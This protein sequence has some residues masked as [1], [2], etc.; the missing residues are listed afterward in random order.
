MCTIIFSTKSLQEIAIRNNNTIFTSIK[1][2]ST[3]H[4]QSC[5]R[6]TNTW[7][8]EVLTETTKCIHASLRMKAPLV[9]KSVSADIS[10]HISCVNEK[11]KLNSAKYSYNLSVYY[12]WIC[13]YLMIYDYYCNL[14]P[15]ENIC[16]TGFYNH[17]MDFLFIFICSLEPSVLVRK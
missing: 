9:T 13:K 7:A 15:Y 16:Y 11:N 6:L 17:L 1:C 4:F 8:C 3:S 5:I 12:V 10:L 2:F 14:S